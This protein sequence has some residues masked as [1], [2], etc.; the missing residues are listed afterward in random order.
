[1]GTPSDCGE[2]HVGSIHEPRSYPIHERSAEIALAIE[3]GVLAAH[4]MVL[5]RTGRCS[6]RIETS[7]KPL[8]SCM[9]AVL[10]T[11]R[12]GRFDGS[13]SW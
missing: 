10:D 1:M 4:A 7:H 3:E 8:Q 5:V 9:G 11:V 13:S 2:A 12:H 6:A